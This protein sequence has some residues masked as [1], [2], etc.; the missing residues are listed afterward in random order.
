[1]NSR[2]LVHRDPAMASLIGAI[3]SDFGAESSF[4]A[5]INF[6][7]D[8]DFGDD[9]NDMGDDSF[10]GG[11]I[12]GNAFG[13]E[14]PTQQ[15]AMAEWQQMKMNT[16]RRGLLL[17]PN[18]GSEITVERYTFSLSQAITLG[19][20]LAAFTTLNGTPDTAIRPQRVTMNAPTPMYAFISAIRMANVN[21][22]VGAGVEDAYNYNPDGVGM[23][24]DMPTLS[25]SNRATVN[26]NYTGF[27]PPGFV[28]GTATNFTVSFK[29]PSTLAA[30]G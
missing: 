23:S 6:G 4:G 21:V 24:L 3:G 12:W 15:A 25:P 2:Q 5:D 11:P 17:K 10:A 14:G 8:V 29:G 1:M 30:G 22:T 7:G 28:G 13:Q 26:G 27:V 16:A 20:P 18:A 9:F 19:T